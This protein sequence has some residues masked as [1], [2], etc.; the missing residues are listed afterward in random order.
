MEYDSLSI[1]KNVEYFTD[2]VNIKKK[3]IEII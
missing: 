1:Y 3:I 2:E